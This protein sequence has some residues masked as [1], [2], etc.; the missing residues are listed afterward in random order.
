MINIFKEENKHNAELRRT[1]PGAKV[2]YR[3][4]NMPPPPQYG[5]NFKEYFLKI[6]FSKK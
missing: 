5:Q 1:A 3:K 4:F 2:S 6:I